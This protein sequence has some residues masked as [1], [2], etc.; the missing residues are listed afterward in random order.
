MREQVILTVFIIAVAFRAEP[1][2]QFGIA[3][4]CPPADRT[5]MLGNPG[6]RLFYCPPVSCLP[7]H[8]MQIRDLMPHECEE[9][10]R[11]IQQR[12]DDRDLC[13]KIADEKAVGE[14]GHIQIG[15]PFDLDRYQEHEQQLHVRVQECKS[16]EQG[17]IDV[18]GIHQI[19]LSGDEICD[20]RSDDGKDN[21]CKI[22]NIKSEG[23]PGTFERLSQHIVKI[24]RK[25]KKDNTAVGCLDQKG[26]QPP[27]LSAQDHLR[28][29]AQI[30]II[31]LRIDDL[32][33]QADDV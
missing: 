23:A 21:P 18:V 2:F 1:E 4:A 17:H 22:I 25:D 3:V 30:V 20:K 5:F 13:P 16:Q 19:N 15:K 10:D 8:R 14:E 6:R 32:S 28:I 9:K 29:Q 27:Y 31:D 33:D 12:H 7:F 26:Y 24:Q 11:K